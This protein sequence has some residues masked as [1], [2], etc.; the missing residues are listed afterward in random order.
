MKLGLPC[1]LEGHNQRSPLLQVF[2]QIAPLSM[3]GEGPKAVLI[4]VMLQVRGINPKRLAGIK[5]LPD[6]LRIG[7]GGLSPL[8]LPVL[9]DHCNTGGA[10]AVLTLMHKR[11]IE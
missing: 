11:N 10:A 5:P 4:E 8:E 3:K 7:T 2:F 9:H 1:G 6:L